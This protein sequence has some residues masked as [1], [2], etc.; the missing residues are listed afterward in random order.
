MKLDYEDFLRHRGFAR[1]ERDEP[2]R[3]ELVDLRPETTDEVAEWIRVV[4]ERFSGIG[5]GQKRSYSEIAANAALVLINVACYL[6]DKQVGRLAADFEE[7]GGFS[8]RLY[9]ARTRRRLS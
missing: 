6:L 5:S 1:W 7:G 3:Q 8:E 2:L 9:R 4:H